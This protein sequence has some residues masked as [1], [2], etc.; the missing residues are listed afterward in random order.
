MT[1]TSSK[2]DKCGKGGGKGRGGEGTYI[3]TSTVARSDALILHTL[4]AVGSSTALCA[5]AEN[6]RLLHYMM[7]VVNNNERR[8]EIETK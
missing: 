6:N 4:S 1:N 2:R 5:R 8:K 7:M 3:F